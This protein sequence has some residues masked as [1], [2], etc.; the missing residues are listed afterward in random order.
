MTTPSDLIFPIINGTIT[1]STT[2]A[3]VLAHRFNTPAWKQGI[4]ASDPFPTQPKK[5]YLAIADYTKLIATLAHN[6][7]CGIIDD[8]H[9]Y[10][11]IA[12]DRPVRPYFDLEWDTAQRDEVAVLTTLIP[13]IFE[14]LHQTGFQ[15]G[16]GI[17]IYTA[18]GA[19][20]THTFPSGTKSSFHLLIDTHEVFANVAQHKLFIETVLL[21]VIKE[22][23]SLS[24]INAKNFPKW[25]LD[26]SPYS[27]NQVFRLP[28]QSKHVTGLS[29]PLLLYD[30]ES[31]GYTYSEV[32]TIGI[33]QDPTALTLITMS[34]SH[35]PAPSLILKAGVES[36]EF[37]K[38]AELC[39]CLNTEFLQEYE[40]TRNLIWMLW[41]LEQTERMRA[42]IHSSCRRGCNYRWAWVEE[43]I[44]GFKFGGFTMGSL[45][46]WAREA[47]GP[48]TVN[49]IIAK[50]KDVYYQELF[51][52][53]MIPTQ[54]RE[55]NQRYL[56][57][58]SF[59]QNDTMLLLSHLGTGKTHSITRLIA[60]GDYQRILII[61]PR[62]SYTTAQVGEFEAESALPHLQS[63]LDHS[64]PLYHIDYLILQVESLH[65]IGEW[66][67]P[68]DLVIMDESESIL[69]QLHSTITNGDNLINNHEVMELA[70]RTAKKVI[71]A[72]AFMTDRTFHFARAMRDP[73]K[74]VFIENKFQP[75]AREAI[76][77]VGKEV[78]MEGFYER[79]MTALRAGR[80]IVVVW[81]SK[82]IGEEFEERLKK[83][84]FKYLFYHSDST[85]EEQL[86]LKNVEESWSNIQ[87]L[88]MTTS[89][90]VGISYDP[91]LEDAHF[92]EAFLY[93][94]S[95]TALPRDIAQS[96]L[97]VRVLKANRLTYVT[98]IPAYAVEECGFTNVCNLLTAKEDELTKEHPLVKWTLCPSWA[99]WNHAYNENERRCS[100]TYYKEV[101]E[102]YLVNSGYTLR[103][104]L[105]EVT[106]TTEEV[107]EEKH[108][109]EWDDIVDISK[110]QAEEIHREIRM[111]NSDRWDK[112]Q[113]QKYSFREQFASSVDEEVIREF[114][115]KFVMFRAT[116]KFWNV[117][118]EKRMSL[119]EMVRG[120]AKRRFAPMVT[121]AIKRRET[122][123][124]F[125]GIMGLAHSQEV[126]VLTHEQLV[127]VGPALCANEAELRA[128]MGLRASQRK[129]EWK[130]GNTIDL[131]RVILE[132]WGGGTAR[133]EGKHVK[134]NKVVSKEFTLYL[135][136]KNTLWDSIRDYHGKM[137][138]FIIKF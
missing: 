111:G 34:A 103:E 17:A 136:E 84:E 71:L 116:D 66:F 86:G 113:Y 121:N 35:K 132:E 28:Q 72:D 117:V 91:R 100:C 19:C 77:L 58:I 24:W 63:Y 105:E 46:K 99:R 131:I 127:E 6:E 118:L 37:P 5:E 133:S 41:A 115:E 78:N 112:L 36:V 39:A 2:L 15:G 49:E 57:P 48:D 21:P 20:G 8:A 26:K 124:R 81:T 60:Y 109:V 82:R 104:E 62:K 55:L 67:Q 69:C 107:Q 79:I 12:E 98:N 1:A 59:E 54:H 47:V 110:E 130:V 126:A 4:V 31:I 96:L 16:N 25:V 7:S 44:K 53:T 76:R 9:L 119:E 93:G 122:L 38:A 125:L 13:I 30:C 50:Y 75:Y 64:G 80:R 94:T 32:Y 51:Q 40:S 52:T 65:R 137:D 89:I 128:G 88:M 95:T 123:R 42:L 27:K 129:G 87:C 73:S 22:E 97:R 3:P 92:D 29:R 90:T 108:G 135:N 70:V 43:I 10:E 68:Y 74:M 106:V 14:C 138:D 134:K 33:Y 56:G 101:L 85:K 45:V 102:K 61:S 18:S 120:E 23:P 83:E 114:W 11:V